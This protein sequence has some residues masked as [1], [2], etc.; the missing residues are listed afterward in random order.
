MPKLRCTAN[1]FFWQG[2]RDMY[3]DLL[4]QAYAAVKRGNPKA[5]VLGCSTAGIDHKFIK[6]TIELGAPFDILTIHP[7]RATLSDRVFVADLAKAADTARQPDGTPRPVWITEMGWTTCTPHNGPRQDFAAT[8]PRDQ[9]RLLARAY[10]D[11][12][13]SGFAPNISWYDF[14]N[15]GT[16]PFNFEHNMG[17]LLRDFRP[18]PAY[19]AYATM[20]RLLKGKRTEVGKAPD[21]GKDVLAYRFADADGRRPVFALWAERA[22]QTVAIPATRAATLTDLMGGVQTIEP[23]DGKVTI[24]LA[25]GTPVFL[26]LDM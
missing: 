18:K 8:S 20:T 6:R 23:K 12:I 13:A 22:E 11:A 19:R 14:R 15:D 10:I 21:L 16:D 3:A 26:S 2:P 9:A 4:K 17:I 5:Q 1:I 7:Y 25:P 24:T